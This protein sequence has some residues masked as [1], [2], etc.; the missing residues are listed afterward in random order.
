[1]CTREEKC[2]RVDAEEDAGEGE[3]GRGP[4]TPTPSLLSSSLCSPFL[5]HPSAPAPA[6][7]LHQRHLSRPP[8]HVYAPEPLVHGDVLGLPPHPAPTRPPS[9]RSP[10]HSARAA[11]QANGKGTPPPPRAA[12][13]AGAR[14]KMR[15]PD[16]HTPLLHVRCLISHESRGRGG[17]RAEA[18][19]AARGGRRPAAPPAATAARS[20]ARPRLHQQQHADIA[21]YIYS[22]SPSQSRPSLP[23]RSILYNGD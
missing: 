19:P 22:F 18:A 21:Y 10:S 1:M 13:M 5:H 16:M 2:A 7:L 9:G 14:T 6:L 17:A 23:H 12:P 4:T 15:A 8:D 20:P 3:V 11:S